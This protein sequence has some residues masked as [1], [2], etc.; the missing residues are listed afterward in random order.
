M[1][2]NKNFVETWW[3]CSTRVYYNFT[4]FIQNW[5]KNKKVWIIDCLMEVSS[6]KVPVLDETAV[7]KDPL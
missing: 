6:I 1:G 4:K 7:D 3:S 5:M 2:T